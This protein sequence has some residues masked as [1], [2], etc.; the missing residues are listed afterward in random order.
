[1]G[2]HFAVTKHPPLLSRLSWISHLATRV[3]LHAW[4]V[5]LPRMR[6]KCRCGETA[7]MNRL[8]LTSLRVLPSLLILS[9]AC[10]D[11]NLPSCKM[12]LPHV[13]LC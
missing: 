2:T 11:S 8:D 3:A 7:E 5:R 9:P 10:L 6:G 1:M 12:S 13:G 4:L